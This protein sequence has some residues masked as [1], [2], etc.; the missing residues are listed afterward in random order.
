MNERPGDNILWKVVCEYISV[1]LGIPGI[2]SFWNH[3]RPSKVSRKS[4]KNLFLKMPNLSTNW[5]LNENPPQKH[6]LQVTLSSCYHQGFMF[7]YQMPESLSSLLRFA[8]QIVVFTKIKLTLTVKLAKRWREAWLKCYKTLK[9][10][11]KEKKDLHHSQNN[12][13][14]GFQHS[15]RHHIYWFPM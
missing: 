15:W 12:A 10:K 5:I 3:I 11:K 7:R 9:K 8:P 14:F 2:T 1:H 13:K 4:I 6:Y